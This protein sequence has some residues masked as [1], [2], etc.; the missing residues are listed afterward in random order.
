[1]NRTL[2]FMVLGGVLLAGCLDGRSEPPAERCVEPTG[3]DCIQAV[4]AGAPEDYAT[5]ADI[6]ELA[7][8]TPDAD[9][10]YHV[11]RGQ[12]VTVVTA[13][14]L[15]E[16]YTRFYLERQPPGSPSPVAHEQR[17]PPL[18]TTYT[19]APA[20][21]EKGASLISFDLRA[22]EPRSGLEPR[23]GDIVVTTR[24]VVPTVRYDRLDTTG[25]A[26]IAGSYA[27]LETPGDAAS[28]FDNF[29]Y[30]SHEGV[31]LRIH[32]TDATGTSRDAL[33][34]TVQVGDMFDYRPDGLDC[35]YRLRVTSVAAI[36]SP[37]TFGI[38]RAASYG[39]RCEGLAERSTGARDVEFVW[40]VR[41]GLPGRDGVR[42]TIPFERA[43]PGT[44]RL[45][46]RSLRVFDVP[47]GMR[48]VVTHWRK[49]DFISG[50]LGFNVSLPTPFVRAAADYTEWTDIKDV[51][52]GSVLS[53]NS[54]TGE[55]IDRGM[56]TDPSSGDLLFRYPNGFAF[57]GSGWPR[58]A[59]FPL[60]RVTILPPVD[61]LF[62][63]TP[64]DKVFDQ[65]VAS[66][67]KVRPLASR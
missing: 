32:P 24:F 26:T 6:P 40:G 36:A 66:L 14:P 49:E 41:W 30:A 23:L 38:E 12:Q 48:V 35:G 28:A 27:F 44:Y 50:H 8:I 13:A 3:A 34:D 59:R 51:A 11:E 58:S 37:R 62:V 4:Y 19:F 9:G 10:R 22:G 52:T 5:V 45:G 54:R 25:R 47:A 7:L 55:E 17:V 15:P 63:R 53:I 61:V 56:S 64:L 33:L 39:R 42:E 60:D 1:M 20:S 21:D 57:G 2:L 46:R 18:G 29:V 16:G 65:I 31:E 67:R 43:G